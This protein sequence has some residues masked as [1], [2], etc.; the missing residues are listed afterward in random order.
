MLGIW[1]TR[2]L[3]HERDFFWFYFTLKTVHSYY[4]Y[5]QCCWAQLLGRSQYVAPN[6][7]FCA[8][9]IHLSDV[10]L[11]ALVISYVILEVCFRRRCAKLKCT[12]LYCH[13]QIPAKFIKMISGP[14]SSYSWLYSLWYDYWS[15]SSLC[16]VLNV[17][18][19]IIYLKIV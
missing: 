7:I 14:H 15:L 17:D 13:Y 8:F 3:R 18:E 12:E 6:F 16:G 5:I 11:P 19:T 2:V 1:S 9:F 4:S 10:H